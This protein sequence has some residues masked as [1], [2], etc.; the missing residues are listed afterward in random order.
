MVSRYTPYP[1]YDWAE[2]Y[3]E[4]DGNWVRHEDYEQLENK[5]NELKKE[6]LKLKNNIGYLN[7]S[8]Y[9][10]E[11]ILEKFRLGPPKTLEC[12]LEEI[13]HDLN[14]IEDPDERCQM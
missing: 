10:A 6:N 4:T 11:A 14:D 1:G 8:L 5:Y 12:K 9:M 7:Q 13:E 3:Y 2:M